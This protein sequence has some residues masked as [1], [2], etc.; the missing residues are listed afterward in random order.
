MKTSNTHPVIP[1]DLRTD[2]IAKQTTQERR[3]DEG[4]TRYE[5]AAE[6]GLTYVTTIAGMPLFNGS[7]EQFARFHELLGTPT[8]V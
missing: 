5:A 8:Q 2:L 1:V 3:E 6:A 4:M 7:P